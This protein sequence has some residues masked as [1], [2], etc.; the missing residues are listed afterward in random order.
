[1]SSRVL[2]PDG[3]APPIGYANGIETTPGKMV[4]VAGQVGWDAN[5]KFTSEELVPQLN[6]RCGTCCRCLPS[7]AAGR[8]TFAGSR[9]I[10][11]TSAPIWMVGRNSAEFGAT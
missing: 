10:A 3:W 2:F 6:R 9:P 5:Q 7:P 8:T 11:L 4:F 1:M